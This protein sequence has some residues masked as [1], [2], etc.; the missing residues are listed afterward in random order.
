MNLNRPIID[1]KRSHM[2]LK[3]GAGNGGKWRKT[4]GNGGKV[5]ET[6]GSGGKQR[7]LAWGDLNRGHFTSLQMNE[8]K[9]LG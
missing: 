4:A 5:R 9:E 1:L 2:G 6:A 8:V 7:L 3:Q